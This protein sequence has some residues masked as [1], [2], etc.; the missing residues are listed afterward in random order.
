MFRLSIRELLLLMAL[1]AVW[2]GWRIDRRSG[3]RDHKVTREH[4]ERLRETL[5]DAKE[6]H[7]YLVGVIENPDGRHCAT[8]RRFADWTFS[9][10]PIP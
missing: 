2:L 4:A 1:L 3:E 7:D 5:R 6:E 9:D 8:Q 10:K